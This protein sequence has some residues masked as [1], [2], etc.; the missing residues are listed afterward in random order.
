MHD[1]YE[2]GCQV[3]DAGRPQVVQNFQPSSNS[4]PHAMQFTIVRF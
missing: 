4:V 3:A 2:P 1:A